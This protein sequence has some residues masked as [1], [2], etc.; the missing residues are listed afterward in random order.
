MFQKDQFVANNQDL[1]FKITVLNNIH[2]SSQKM[3][4]CSLNLFLFLFVALYYFRNTNVKHL[5]HVIHD[6][7]TNNNNLT[8]R[9]YIVLMSHN[10]NTT[11]HQQI[12]QMVTG[13]WTRKAHICLCCD[14]RPVCLI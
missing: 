5:T 14:Q 4:H 8:P 12:K 9:F 2:K 11:K 3:Y 13:P 6:F 10:I 1:D 7:S